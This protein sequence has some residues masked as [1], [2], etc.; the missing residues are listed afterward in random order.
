MGDPQV[1]GLPP[2]AH[3]VTDGPDAWA[4]FVDGIRRATGSL[5]ECCAWARAWEQNGNQ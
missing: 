5:L 3:V 1:A 4:L 2:R